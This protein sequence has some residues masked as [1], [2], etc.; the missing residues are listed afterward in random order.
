MPTYRRHI[1][2]G[3]EVLREVPGVPVRTLRP[4]IDR[5]RDDA[6]A[7]NAWLRGLRGLSL[8]SAG[9]AAE[10]QGAGGGQHFTATRLIRQRHGLI[11]V[12]QAFQP[13]I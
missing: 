10:G 8:L 4:A 1:D 9:S 12:R 7:I 3:M 11:L 5:R 13:D 2:F 6:D